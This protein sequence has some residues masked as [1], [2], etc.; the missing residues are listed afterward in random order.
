MPSSLGEY[1]EL[2]LLWAFINNTAIHTCFLVIIC[3][4]VNKAEFTVFIHLIDLDLIREN[5]FSIM[6]DSVLSASSAYF[7]SSSVY[8]FELDTAFPFYLLRN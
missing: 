8:P 4:I 2:F 1:F 7:V 3:N 5:N 6:L